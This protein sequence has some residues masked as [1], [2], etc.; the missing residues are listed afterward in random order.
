MFA[1]RILLAL[2]AVASSAWVL[3][4]PIKDVNLEKRGAV[5]TAQYATE[6]EANGRFILGNNLWGLS[7]DPSG[8]QSSQ[9][10]AAN[11]NS[12]S[13]RTTYAWSGAPTQVK[14][15]ANLDLRSGIG[16]TLA[17]IQSIPT[18]WQWSYSSA[19]SNLVAD[20]SYDLWLSKTA[21]TTGATSASTYEI[22]IWLSARGGA[23][24]AGSQVGTV[25]ING[26]NWKLFKGVVGSWNIFSFVAPS[27]MTN[28]NEDLKP[29]FNYLV[30][31]QGVP[32]NQFLVQAQSGTEPFVGSATLTT[33]SYSL[34]IN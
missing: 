20:V 32:S 22:M 7:A 6:T 9:A 13:W 16:K 18:S 24:P 28:F 15:Y 12:V 2:A 14:S 33:Q 29:F 17:S 19:S 8:S 10:T 1:L 4:T 23:T 30:S 11:G 3:A 26:L 34:A 31:S 25:N 27:E 21:G 5:L